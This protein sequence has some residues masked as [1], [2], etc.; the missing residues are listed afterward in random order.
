[1]CIRDRDD[2]PTK[3]DA[4]KSFWLKPAADEPMSEKKDVKTEDVPEF[5]TRDSVRPLLSPPS[6]LEPL[7]P[8]RAAGWLILAFGLLYMIGAG[9]YFGSPLLN[10]PIDLLPIAGIAV[11][12]MLPL[13]LLFLLWRTLKHLSLITVSY[14]HLTLPTTPYV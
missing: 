7:K 3:A 11:L 2:A 5:V 13:I 14:T 1:M 12:L 6:S 8:P 9:L 10:Q 4:P